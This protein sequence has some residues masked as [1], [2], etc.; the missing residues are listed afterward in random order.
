[1]S[2][3][4]SQYRE[5]MTTVPQ[6]QREQ[7][8]ELVSS[9][10]IDSYESFVQFCQA[11]I[12]ATVGGQISPDVAKEVRGFTEQM[13][14]ALAHKESLS[15]ESGGTETM[16]A[17]FGAVIQMEKQA[18]LIRQTATFDSVDYSTPAQEVILVESSDS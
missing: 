8:Q 3:Q 17:V 7:V 5:W 15:S 12:V 4:V 18:K 14:M 9:Y 1:M 10:T 11:L 6:E 13:L 2:R 16:K